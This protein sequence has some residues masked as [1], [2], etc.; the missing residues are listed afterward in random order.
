MR[1]KFPIAI[2][3]AATRIASAAGPR[4]MRAL[5][6]FNRYVTNPI[7]RLWAP[8]LP[9]MA[10]LEHTGRKSGNAYRTPVMVFI[11]S[12]TFIVPLNYGTGSDWVRNIQAAGA[13]GAVHRGRRYRLT[14]PRILPADSPD[15]PAA[16]RGAGIPGRSVLLADL[17]S[18]ENR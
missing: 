8:Y 1:K 5:A 17:V 9:Y 4:R 12:D 7:Q 10:I 18:E 16:L 2:A 14:D 6:R 13:A 3:R 11:E 15:L